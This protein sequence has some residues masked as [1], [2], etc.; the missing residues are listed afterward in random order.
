MR[1][2]IEKEH[3]SGRRPK[4]I[5]VCL[6]FTLHCQRG[7]KVAL[8]HSFCIDTKVYHQFRYILAFPL[9]SSPLSEKYMEEQLSQNFSQKKYEGTFVTYGIGKSGNLNLTFFA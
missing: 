5:S 3:S 4:S 9:F 8:L 1:V 2:G 6:F 7:Q